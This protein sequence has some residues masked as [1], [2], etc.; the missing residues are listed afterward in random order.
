VVQ[1]DQKGKFDGMAQFAE[2]IRTFIEGFG[3]LP[4]GQRILASMDP[5]AWVLV[6]LLGSAV[7]VGLFFSL[8]T[9]RTFL[10]PDEIEATPQMLLARLKQDPTRLA[11]IA[12]ISR[13]GADATLELLEYGDQ[14]R[15]I[16]SGATSGAAYAKSCWIC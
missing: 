1:S 9:R 11:P 13:L 6:I 8:T 16:T 7:V 10:S 2:A 15:T 3:A 5:V 12:I 14:L 4:S